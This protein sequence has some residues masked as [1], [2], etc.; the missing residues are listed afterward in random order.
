[1]VLLP[2][3]LLPMS[4]SV[5]FVNERSTSCGKMNIERTERKGSEGM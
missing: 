3:M 5:G 4:Y 1:M 2:H